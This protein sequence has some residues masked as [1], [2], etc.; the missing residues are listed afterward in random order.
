MKTMDLPVRTARDV[1]LDEQGRRFSLASLFEN[2]TVL[3]VIW[4]VSPVAGVASGAALSVMAM[5]IGARQGVVAIFSLIAAH[6]LTAVG[7]EPHD[8][9]PLFARG[10]CVAGIA[11]LIVGWYGFRRRISCNAARQSRNS[12]NP[13][14]KETAELGMNGEIGM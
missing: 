2:V 9:T 11:C 10:V 3:C 13:Q 8:E 5:A 14:P 4:A 6:F 7:I 12:F 1:A